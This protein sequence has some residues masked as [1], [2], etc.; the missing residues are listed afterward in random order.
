[1]KTS[2][3]NCDVCGAMCEADEHGF[4]PFALSWTY[5]AMSPYHPK[6]D[7]RPELSNAIGLPSVAKDACSPKCLAA[8]L[9]S[10]AARVEELAAG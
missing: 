5:L 3:F 2:L 10:F 9:R 1:M 6:I 4:K 8:L 7:G